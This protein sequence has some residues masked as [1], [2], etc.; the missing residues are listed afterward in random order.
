M[1]NIETSAARPSCDKTRGFAPPDHSEFAFVDS[2]AKWTLCVDTL[3]L[4]YRLNRNTEPGI[5]DYGPTAARR[6]GSKAIPGI[7]AQKIRPLCHRD[8]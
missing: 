8:S 2:T 4:P 3:L 7:R 1:L 6:S 5:T